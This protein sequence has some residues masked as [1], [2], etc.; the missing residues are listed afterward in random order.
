MRIRPP[1]NGAALKLL[2][3]QNLAPILVR[4]LAD[5]YP[6]STHVR[7]IGLQEADDEDIWRHAAIEGFA[8]VTK[9]DDYRQRSFVRGHPPKVIWVRLGNCTT[10][11]VEQVLRTRCDDVSKFGADNQAALLVLLRPSR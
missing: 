2:F 4:R 9:D 3:D 1:E 8:I 10:A 11:E 6:E 5:L 7:D